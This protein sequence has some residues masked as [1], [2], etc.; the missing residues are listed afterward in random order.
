MANNIKLILYPVKDIEKAKTFYGKLLG[1]EPYADS[2]YYIGYKAGE[3]EVGLVPNSSDDPTA[4]IEVDD[5]NTALK[6]MTDAGAEITQEP[7]DV[8]QGLLV[9]KFKDSDGNM[10]GYRQQPKN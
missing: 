8:A 2:P 5:I 9:A 1:V 3:L 6:I 7:T 10:F 4:Y